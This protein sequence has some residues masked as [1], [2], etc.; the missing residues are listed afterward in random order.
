MVVDGSER[1]VE[2]F[3]W[4]TRVVVFVL[5]QRLAESIRLGFGPDEP[6]AITEDCTDERGRRTLEVDDVDVVGPERKCEIGTEREACFELAW[7]TAF[8]GDG[9]VD[10]ASLVNPTA[11]TRAEQEPHTDGMVPECLGYGIAD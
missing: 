5:E 2:S 1:I 3:G 6:L 11:C 10:V 9:N 4:R 8:E 7:L